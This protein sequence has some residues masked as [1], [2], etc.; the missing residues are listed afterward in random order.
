M[1]NM[2]NIIKLTITNK[3]KYMLDCH[4]PNLEHL[5][6][7][8][9]KLKT[10]PFFPKLKYLEC[11]HN[12]LTELPYYENLVELICYDNQLPYKSNIDINVLNILQ[13]YL[14]GF[15]KLYFLIV[16]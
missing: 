16:V 10:L 15:F 13:I 7:D 4:L 9:L 8:N 1:E 6:Y 2:E 3:N 12:L 14:S 11:H 5:I